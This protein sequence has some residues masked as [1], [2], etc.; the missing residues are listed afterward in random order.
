MYLANCEPFSNKM[1]SLSFSL[2][3]GCFPNNDFV[4]SLGVDHPATKQETH[5]IAAIL[6]LP[7]PKHVVPSIET[8]LVPISIQKV[9][10]MDKMTVEKKLDMQDPI[11]EPICESESMYESVPE[12]MRE[13]M[14][15]SKKTH[16]PTRRKQV[17]KELASIRHYRLFSVETRAS[18]VLQKLL[19]KSGFTCSDKNDWNIFWNVLHISIRVQV[20]MLK[21]L[22]RALPNQAWKSKSSK[23]DS[24]ILESLELFIPCD[25]AIERMGSSEST[26]TGTTEFPEDLLLAKRPWKFCL[27]NDETKTFTEQQQQKVHGSLFDQL[28]VFASENV[29]EQILIGYLFANKHVWNSQLG[30]LALA[31]VVESVFACGMPLDLDDAILKKI[32]TVSESFTFHDQKEES[33][34]ASTLMKLRAEL[35]QSCFSLEVSYFKC[36]FPTSYLAS[37]MDALPFPAKTHV[38]LRHIQGDS[39]ELLQFPPYS[40]H[41][42]NVVAS[43]HIATGC[44]F[45]YKLMRCQNKGLLPLKVAGCQDKNVLICAHD[46]FFTVNESVLARNK[47][48]TLDVIVILLDPLVLMKKMQEKGLSIL[49]VCDQDNVYL[50]QCGCSVQFDDSGIKE[51]SSLVDYVIFMIKPKK[52][53]VDVAPKKGFIILLKPDVVVRTKKVDDDDRKWNCIAD[54]MKKWLQSSHIG[55]STWLARLPLKNLFVEENRYWIIQDIGV[56][57]RKLPFNLQQKAVQATQDVQMQQT[58]Q[59]I[60]TKTTRVAQ[61]EVSQAE[62]SQGG[63]Q[64]EKV[65]QTEKKCKTEDRKDSTVRK[66]KPSAIKNGKHFLNGGSC[67]RKRRLRRYVAQVPKSDAKKPKNTEKPEQKNSA[68]V[69]MFQ[70]LEFDDKDSLFSDLMPTSDGFVSSHELLM[71]FAA[72]SRTSPIKGHA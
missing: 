8:S 15:G 53:P 44:E 45:I 28:L 37:C 7:A 29:Q 33:R 56:E 41:R 16:S 4:F 27:V 43:P 72:M 68:V 51:K 36:Y 63:A 24:H 49:L 20:S 5:A 58:V 35:N 3:F 60:T 65:L 48:C 13:V 1:V 55:F 6:P 42:Q 22:I 23:K 47:Q 25:F 71:S 34:D 57:T 14:H 39:F 31:S 17:Q 66:E 70:D 2:F 32:S 19:S 46:G 30:I 11:Q 52:L 64:Q 50:D 21:D 12:S 62:V 54:W 9:L 26:W 59:T 61:R 40:K 69:G 18:E 10:P 38:W 67:T